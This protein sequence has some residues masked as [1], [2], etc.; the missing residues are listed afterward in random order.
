M[1][2]RARPAAVFLDRDGVLNRES[3]YVHRIEDFHLLP[4]VPDALRRLNAAGYGLVVITNQAGIAR[5]LY[6]PADFERLTRYMLE[7]LR[8]DGV[9]IDAVYHCPHHPTEG[10][11]RYRISCQCRKPAPGMLLSASADLGIDLAASAL[12]GDKASDIEA[13]RQAGVG[14]C[15]LVGSGHAVSAAD[16]AAADAFATD[17]P[18]AADWIIRTGSSP[19]GT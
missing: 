7:I 13:G 2:V 8:A 19:S 3:G 14:R 6:G 15:V 9:T 17:L 11:G 4:G 12:V 1:N 18:G 16:R 5:G 10:V